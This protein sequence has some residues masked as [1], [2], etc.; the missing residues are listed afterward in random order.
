MI[1]VKHLLDFNVLFFARIIY[2]HELMQHLVSGVVISTLAN[3]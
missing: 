2:Y 3:F 1:S